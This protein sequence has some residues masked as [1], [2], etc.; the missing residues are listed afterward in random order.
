[1]PAHDGCPTRPGNSSRSRDVA[2]LGPCHSPSDIPL[3]GG[4]RVG[5]HRVAADSSSG[6]KR[7]A[8]GFSPVVN[9]IESTAKA[10]S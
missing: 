5:D 3:D 10:E 2:N 4:Q 9:T 6:V 8:Q 1:M 7:V